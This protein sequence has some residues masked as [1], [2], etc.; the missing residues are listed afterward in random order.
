MTPI[1]RIKLD[2]IKGM[3]TGRGALVAEVAMLFALML[4][5]AAQ[6][7]TITV[8]SAGDPAESARA[9]ADVVVLSVLE[10]VPPGAQPGGGMFLRATVKA[11]GARAR[12]PI[13]SFYL[14]KHHMR[15]AHDVNIASETVGRFD[16]PYTVGVV[17]HVPAGMPPGFYFV[18]ACAGLRNCTASQGTIQV[19]GEAI[20]QVN[21]VDGG[22][23]VDPPAPEYF[24]EDP[25]A[26]MTVGAPFD[27]P[28][29]FHGQY[30]SN[31]VF[32]TTKI[33]ALLP[34]DRIPTLMY[35]PLTHRYPYIVAI[36]FDP[37]WLDLSKGGPIGSTNG[38]S[39]TKYNSDSRY[40][41]S[42]AGLDPSDPAQRGYA[43][44]GFSNPSGS[45]GSGQV[46]FMCSDRVPASTLP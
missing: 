40:P 12:K 45:N 13:V 11:G 5:A 8:D 25:A 16:D 19:V 24:P 34:N 31:C 29:S 33:F 21:Q 27:C 9:K 10:P 6:A 20:S 17:G 43:Y 2:R 3:L 35:C 46:R 36:G 22:S 28:I 44:I 15:G 26:G 23:S 32:V 4:S 41:Q 18:L 39:S 42:Y 14:S 38:V 1:N 37:W 30:P 7:A